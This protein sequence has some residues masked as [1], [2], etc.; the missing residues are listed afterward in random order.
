MERLGRQC[1]REVTHGERFPRLAAL[2]QA[3]QAVFDRDNQSTARVLAIIGA[4][5]AERSWL[6][7]GASLFL[8]EPARTV[9]IRRPTRR[10]SYASR[11]AIG[12]ISYMP[13]SLMNPWI[14][15]LQQS[16]VDLAPRRFMR[17]RSLPKP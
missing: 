10:A 15:W 1:R 3:A 14:A 16:F 12:Q 6:Y 4:Q 11:S 7:L 5:A 17:W 2:L 8:A 13:M 9:I